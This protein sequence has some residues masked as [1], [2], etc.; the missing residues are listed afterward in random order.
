M[1]CSNR[2]CKFN[3]EDTCVIIQGAVVSIDNYNML[4]AIQAKLGIA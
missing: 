3:I 2:S 1:D 4:K